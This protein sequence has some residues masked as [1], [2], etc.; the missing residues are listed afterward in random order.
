MPGT[1]ESVDYFILEIISSKTKLIPGF[2][3]TT[4]GTLLLGTTVIVGVGTEIENTKVSWVSQ[5]VSSC[6]RNVR[7]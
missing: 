6:N 2:G 1:V 5:I 4:G 3:G 7:K